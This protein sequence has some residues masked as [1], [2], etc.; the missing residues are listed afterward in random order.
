MLYGL[1]SENIGYKIL[2]KRY[3]KEYYAVAL[4]R[5]PESE[6]LREAVNAAINVMSQRGILNKI[7]SKW[8]PPLHS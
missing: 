5:A 4:R 7:K 3:T 2:P 6:E 8:I 1:V